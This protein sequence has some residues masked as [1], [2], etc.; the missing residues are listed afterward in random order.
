MGLT[1]SRR[2]RR[3][4]EETSTVHPSSANNI[5]E[6]KET[7]DEVCLQLIFMNILQSSRENYCHL[8]SF[9]SFFFTHHIHAYMYI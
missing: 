7:F 6:E 3:G 4:E 9:P 5:D 2:W 1:N 8:S